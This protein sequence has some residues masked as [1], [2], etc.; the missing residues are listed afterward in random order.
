MN[1]RIFV[2][3]LNADFR[4]LADQIAAAADGGADG[5][6]VDIMDGHF[7]P[8]LSLGPQVVSAVRACTGLTVDVHLMIERP[9]HMINAFVEAGADSITIHQEATP[10]ARLVIDQIH[11]LGARAGLALNPGTA[12]SQAT[13]LLQD[14]ETLLLMTVNPGFGG[15]ALIPS[16]IEKVQRARSWLDETQSAAAL[17]VDGG[18]KLENIASLSHAGAD[19]FIAGTSVF[20]VNTDP[21]ERLRALRQQLFT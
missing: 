9:E 19:V 13:E 8:N 18:V 7:V 20:K 14:I 17:Q 2:S 12:L 5:V 3:I 10:H 21:A 1:K 15:Q 4:F 16:T 6:H 11:R